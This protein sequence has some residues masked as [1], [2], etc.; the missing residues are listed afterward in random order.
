MPPEATASGC[1][2]LLRIGATLAGISLVVPALSVTA[3]LGF[4]AIV[5]GAALLRSDRSAARLA[6][7]RPDDVDQTSEDSFPASDPPSW[8]PIGGTGTRH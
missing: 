4:V 7:Q 1:P 2:L 6:Q 8:I 5:G 3:C